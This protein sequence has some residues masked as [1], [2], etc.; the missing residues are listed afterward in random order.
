LYWATTK[1]KGLTKRKGFRQ[2]KVE[3]GKKGKRGGKLRLAT[4]KQRFI[5]LRRKLKKEGRNISR[6]GYTKKGTK[7]DPEKCNRQFEREGKDTPKEV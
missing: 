5:H 1:R 3:G 2:G 6:V 7:T 4:R